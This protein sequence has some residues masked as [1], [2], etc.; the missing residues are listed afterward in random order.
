MT[1]I[2]SLSLG[3]TVC[4]QVE[5]KLPMLETLLQSATSFI[6][7]SRNEC[8]VRTAQEI[9]GSERVEPS[10]PEKKEAEGLWKSILT[11]HRD[12][13]TLA[14][15]TFRDIFEEKYYLST[16]CEVKRDEF[17]R[18]KQGSFFVAEYE[19]MIGL[20]ESDV[21]QLHV[22]FQTKLAGSQEGGAT[23]ILTL[24]LT[25]NWVGPNGLRHHSHDSSA[26][27]ACFF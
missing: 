24:S 6:F 21:S 26:A 23:L 5:V 11:R 3:D 17:L 18:W 12:A 22:V 25:G 13:Y 8:F 2:L 19:R 7:T 14:C 9:G 16:Y 10:D 4:T 27:K 15:K 1:E 20:E